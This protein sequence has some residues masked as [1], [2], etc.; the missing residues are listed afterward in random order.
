MH[1]A[2]QRLKI[3]TRDAQLLRAVRHAYNGLKRTEESAKCRLFVSSSATSLSWLENQLR[4]GEQYGG[5]FQNIKSVQLAETKKVESQCA[6]DEQGRLFF[7]FLN[8]TYSRWTSSLPSC[9]WSQRIFPS[10]PGSRLVFVCVCFLPMHS[11]H[12]VR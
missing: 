7:F 11:G 5:F 1:A 9:L 4:M 8:L 10:L 6:R 3:D 2:W 12:Q